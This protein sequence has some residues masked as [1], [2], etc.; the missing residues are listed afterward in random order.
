MEASVTGKEDLPIIDWTDKLN[1]FDERIRFLVSILPN[2]CS[3]KLDRFLNKKN[4]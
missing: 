1:N 2:D 4:V 3:K